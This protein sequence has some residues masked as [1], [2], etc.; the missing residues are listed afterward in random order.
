[1]LGP[2]KLL[3][4][5]GTALIVFGIL[6]AQTKG[7]DHTPGLIIWSA[8]TMVVASALYLG[9]KKRSSLGH[10]GPVYHMLLSGEL[11]LCGV[12]MIG[13]VKYLHHP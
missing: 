13:M 9:W 1:M 4:R 2:F 12:V 6:F 8:A 3:V 11:L 10:F 7:S 5:L